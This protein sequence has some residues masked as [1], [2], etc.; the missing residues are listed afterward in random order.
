MVQYGGGQRPPDL[1]R[2]SGDRLSASGDSILN[3][4]SLVFAAPPLPPCRQARPSTPCRSLFPSLQP[5]HGRAI[6]RRKTGVSRRPMRAGRYSP[7]GPVGIPMLSRRISRC[8]ASAD[9]PCAAARCFSLDLESRSRRTS[10]TMASGRRSDGRLTQIN[11][12]RLRCAT[13]AMSEWSPG[14]TAFTEGGRG[15]SESSGRGWRSCPGPTFFYR[16]R[17]DRGIG[18][19]KIFRV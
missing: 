1:R 15:P 19:K 8:S 5:C 4:Q 9:R 11:T 14:P 17:E 13:M 16:L 2:A 18:K 7:L 6:A 10:Q 3:P 12:R